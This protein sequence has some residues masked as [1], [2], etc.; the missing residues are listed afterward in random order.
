M[1]ALNPERHFLLKHIGFDKKIIKAVGHYYFDVDGNSYLDFLSQYGAV[2]FGHNP[3]ELLELIYSHGLRQEPSFVQPL[4]SP[5]A[6]ELA[7][8]LVQL[9]PGKMKYAT[10]V[11]SGAEAVEA[12]IKL[13]RARTKRQGIVS[14]IRGYHGKTLGALSAT[15][16]VEYRAPFLLDTTCFDRIPFDDLPA[17]DARLEKRDVAAFLVEPVQ[18]EG[19]MRVPSPGY[20]RGVAEICRKYGTLFV[21]DEIQ[22]G[23]GRTGEL[24]AADE[25]ALAPDIMLLSK[26]LGGGI[27]P[28]GVM[29]CAE[30]VWCEEFGYYHSST[31]ANS[32][33]S[34]SIGCKVLDILMA[35]NRA[36]I[37]HA[38]EMGSYLEK[39][40]NRL[41]EKYPNA[42]I[43]RNGRGL[44]QAIVLAPW[45]GE[46]S[47]FMAY[48]SK[49]GFSVPLLAGYLINKHQI[50]TAPVLNQ[51]ASLRLEPSLT[52]ER[53]EIDHM[54]AALD[55]A[56]NLISTNDFSTLL[57]FVTDNKNSEDSKI[58]ASTLQ[59][60][61]SI[62]Q[63]H[64]PTYRLP[65]KMEK[66][67]GSFAFM[68]HPT[69]DDVLFNSLPQ[70]FAQ[71][72]LSQKTSWHAWMQSWFAR[73]FAPAVIYH[74]PAIRSKA[75]GYI[76]GWLIGAPLTPMSMMK[77]KKEEKK[78]LLDAY[79][80][81]VK[82]LNVDIV[83]L[84]A[85]TSV[86]ARGGNDLQGQGENITTGNSL[87]AIASAE[88]LRAVV[89]AQGKNFS[90]EVVAVIGAAGSIG[91]LTA[92]HVGRFSKNIILFGNPKNSNAL[93]NLLGVAGEVYRTA[94]EFSLIN[95][96][97][98]LPA[99][100]LDN[101]GLAEINRLLTSIPCTDFRQFKIQVEGQLARV[102]ITKPPILVSA[103]LTRD[104]GKANVVISASSAGQ[105][106]INAHLFSSECIVCDIARPLDVLGSVQANRSDIFVYEGGVMK[107]PE[108][109]SFGAQ[110]VL[111]YPR[112]YNLACLSETMVLA[113][114]GEKRSFSIGSTINYAEALSIYEKSL[115]HGFHFAVLINGFERDLT[116]LQ[117]VTPNFNTE[118]DMCEAF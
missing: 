53:F 17:L 118:S 37:R 106:F 93:D 103:D 24:F 108:N 4:I 49:N 87:T 100:L 77:L 5:A 68:I 44:M 52:I 2:P 50:I 23:L 28:L 55:S 35:D 64:V 27:V 90:S 10:F 40:L 104:L 48:A 88:S 34:C 15:D 95:P 76:E 7:T 105:S 113:M 22:T 20:L 63:A 94:A 112:G 116:P 117:I 102:G 111:G 71:L 25:A 72:N 62:P 80:D 58:K 51:N 9:A 114:E 32:H 1:S 54:L 99:L 66:C 39:G 89:A 84:G 67:I 41:V 38:K 79:L 12:S 16:N 43:K 97:S 61:L 82:E 83:G 98:G 46:E 59:A 45:S 3:V 6:E 56:G 85:F 92:L 11:N 60:A 75:G 74:L 81:A 14:A 47:Y 21:L 109:I 8:K 101:I 65:Q 29:L 115:T 13:A 33:F 110:N 86:I 19:G 36:V 107:L 57:S 31:F 30:D 78:A 26:A 70:D 73:M 91:R 96:S 69:D 18:G 42:F